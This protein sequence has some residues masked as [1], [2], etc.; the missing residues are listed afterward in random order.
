MNCKLLTL[1]L[2]DGLLG[3]CRVHRFCGRQSAH[4]LLH[5]IAFHIP[6]EQLFFLGFRQHVRVGIG[7]VSYTHLDVYKRQGPRSV[8]SFQGSL[9]PCLTW[10]PYARVLEQRIE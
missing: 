9:E 1:D 10:P 2:H 7:P 8:D 6:P 3:S 5:Q 4:Q